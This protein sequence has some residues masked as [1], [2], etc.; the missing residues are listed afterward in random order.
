MYLLCTCR[1]F[2]Q[3]WRP[4]AEPASRIRHPWRVAAR[5]RIA[6]DFH[7]R[8]HPDFWWFGHSMGADVD[9]L[10][11]RVTFA[12]W[13]KV[14]RIPLSWLSLPHT[15]ASLPH[16]CLCMR[17]F[18]GHSMPICREGCRIFVLYLFFMLTIGRSAVRFP[19]PQPCWGAINSDVRKSS[20]PILSIFWKPTIHFP[21]SAS[22]LQLQNTEN[23]HTS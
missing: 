16:F 3:A 20:K 22:T 4:S 9:N 21:S 7:G 17:R 18:L 6:C 8:A 1:E 11:L 2:R 19:H 13:N 14:G 23:I 5:R 12:N 15:E 10:L